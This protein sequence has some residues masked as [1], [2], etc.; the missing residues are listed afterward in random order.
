MVVL[1]FT[2]PLG[3]ISDFSVPAELA[4]VTAL[5]IGMVMWQVRAILRAD[6]PAI[7]ATEALATTAPIFLLFFAATYFILSLDDGAT[8]SELLSRSDALYL[9]VT[10]FATVGF[11]DITPQTETARMLV[12]A[13]MLL[14]LVVLGLGI[15]VILGTVKRAKA[16][17]GDTK[18]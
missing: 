9:T 1:Y 10:I 2:L 6:L 3:R 4:V 16:D 18:D 8:F 17:A 14:N 13:Q 7:R 15:Q 12:T 11:G 5:F